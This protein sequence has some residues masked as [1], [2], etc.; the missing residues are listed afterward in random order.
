MKSLILVELPKEDA[1]RINV[2]EFLQSS[3]IFHYFFCQK[4]LGD[5]D[6]AKV[7]NTQLSL[8]GF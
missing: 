2:K 5:P 7:N 3:E 4:K 1:S 6:F 8:I